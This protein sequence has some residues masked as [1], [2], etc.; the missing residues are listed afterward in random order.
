MCALAH[1]FEAAGLSTIVITSMREIA[2]RMGVPRTL[3]ASFPLGRPLGKPRNKKF[4]SEVLRAAFSLLTEPEGPVIKDFPISVSPIASEP[5]VCQLPPILS[6]EM[7]PASDEAVAVK[8]A[9]D[10]AYLKTGRTSVGKTINA[11]D[12]PST[13]EKFARIAAGESWEK[14]G[15]TVASIYCTSLDVRSYYEEVA[16]EIADNPIDPWATE[17]WFYEKT[18]AGQL[19]L[20]ARRAMRDNGVDKSAW[21]GLVPAG[22]E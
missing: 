1:V 22:R 7:H 6:H 19:I 5:L 9:Y 2:H 3:H 11:D 21:F 13:L 12:M 4:Q 16:S 8:P 17:Q 15:F 20:N 10:R 18:E 14:L